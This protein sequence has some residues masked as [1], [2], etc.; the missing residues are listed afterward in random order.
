MDIFPL[1]I[2][3]GV[4]WVIYSNVKAANKGLNKVGKTNAQNE[5]ETRVK[6]KV[7]DDWAYETQSYR[8]QTQNTSFGQRSGPTQRGR[9]RLKQR[10]SGESL[11]QRLQAASQME[12]LKR[13]S[14]PKEQN[15]DEGHGLSSRHAPQ[16]DQNRN[17]RDDW[18]QRGGEIITT[19]SILVILALVFIVLYIL[20]K[21]SS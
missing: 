13:K 7:K 3:L 4:G 5:F 20:S 8:K 21:T 9:E 15:S 17:R 16:K 12:S 2:F 10:G 11:Q 6:A 14:R 19:K 1:I 18:G